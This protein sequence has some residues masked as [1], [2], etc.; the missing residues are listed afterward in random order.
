VATRPI[1]DFDAYRQQLTNFVYHS[2]FVMKPVF[3]AAK[4]APRRVLL[5]KRT[6]F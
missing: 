3:A 6:L 5:A 4:A 2:G 1:T